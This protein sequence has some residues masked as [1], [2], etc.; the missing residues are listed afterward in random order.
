MGA[1]VAAGELMVRL[2]VEVFLW[3]PVWGDSSI[4]VTEKTPKF[5][6]EFYRLDTVLLRRELSLYTVVL[7]ARI[8]GTWVVK[9]RVSPSGLLHGVAA[10]AACCGGGSWD[11]AQ[12]SAFP[13][14]VVWWLSWNILG[15]LKRLYRGSHDHSHHGLVLWR[16][17][18]HKRRDL[19]VGKHVWDG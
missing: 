19:A 8:K 7:L 5:T 1:I 14:C 18:R 15:D 11:Q 12:Q 2:L 6:T 9:S 17:R 3:S 13:R 16:W 4:D 10:S